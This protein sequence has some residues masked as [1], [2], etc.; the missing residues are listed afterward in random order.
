MAKLPDQLLV[1]GTWRP[2]FPISGIKPARLYKG[3]NAEQTR[4]GEIMYF[5]TD[6]VIPRP[7]GGK[8]AMKA[9]TY[10][11]SMV[12]WPLTSHQMR[13]KDNITFEEISGCFGNDFVF[14]EAR[15][16]EMVLFHGAALEMDRQELA[17]RNPITA[18]KK[19]P[20]LPQHWTNIN[21]RKSP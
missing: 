14:C 10:A 5:P 13:Y 17:G 3:Q 6:I 19:L 12:T 15:R 16:H 21:V 9:G 20:P 8:L 18:K 7:S 4:I 2:A 1:D 11:C